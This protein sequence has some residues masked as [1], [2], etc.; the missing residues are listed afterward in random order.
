MKCP[1]GDPA[2]SNPG[3]TGA[4]T[5]TTFTGKLTVSLSGATKAQM[6]TATKAS[7]AAHF[8]VAESGVTVTATESRRLSEARNLAGSWSI[9]FSFTVPTSEAAAVETKVAALTTSSDAMKTLLKP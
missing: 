5:T 6:E 8:G 9:A 2:T 4:S 7:I 1:G 3:T